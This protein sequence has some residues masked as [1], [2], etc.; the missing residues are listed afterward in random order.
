MVH[1]GGDYLVTA[2][3]LGRGEGAVRDVDGQ[4]YSTPPLRSSPSYHFYYVRDI[5]WYTLAA[6]LSNIHLLKAKCY[7]QGAFDAGAGKM[8]AGHTIPLQASYAEDARTITDL[9]DQIIDWALVQLRTAPD[10]P[11]VLSKS[12]LLRQDGYLVADN[13]AT[14]SIALNIAP[15]DY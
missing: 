7:L 10:G 12:A 8:T 13:G 1:Q 2:A 11:A 15:G 4:S 6:D 9:P 3:Y 14:E 5:E